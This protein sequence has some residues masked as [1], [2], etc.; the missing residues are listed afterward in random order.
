MIEEQTAGRFRKNFNFVHHA[1]EYLQFC[2]ASTHVKI[3][4]PAYL[5]L[6]LI[7]TRT[8][9]QQKPAQWTRAHLSALLRHRRRLCASS[10]LFS[11]PELQA[12]VTRQKPNFGGTRIPILRPGGQVDRAAAPAPAP[13]FGLSCPR[14]AKNHASPASTIPSPL[15]AMKVAS[16]LSRRHMMIPSRH[17]FHPWLFSSPSTQPIPPPPPPAAKAVE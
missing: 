9:T 6:L 17:C 7:Q 16:I 10:Y 1:R 11:T 15:A 5:L 14:S 3:S 2:R 8:S 12:S 13:D 4:R